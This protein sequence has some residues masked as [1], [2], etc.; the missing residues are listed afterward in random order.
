[1]YLKLC[2]PYSIRSETEASLSSA[3]ISHRSA[4]TVADI[5]GLV[6]KSAPQPDITP[7]SATT[8]ELVSSKLHFRCK[9]RFPDGHETTIVHKKK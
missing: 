5:L 2:D 9:T 4:R 7:S 8:K 6:G 3:F 1:M